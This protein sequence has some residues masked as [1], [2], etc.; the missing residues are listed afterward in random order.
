MSLFDELLT[1]R[2]I[3]RVCFVSDYL[4]IW[5]G[6]V[7]L[8]INNTAEFVGGSAKDLVGQ[9]VEK[10]TASDVAFT[11][12]FSDGLELRVGLADT[13]YHSPEAMTLFSEKC[14]YVVW[15]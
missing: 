7:S 13:G 4:Q 10:V 6:D 2:R 8:N 9:I 11:L 3:T 12:C 15:P 5:L 1:G 14:G